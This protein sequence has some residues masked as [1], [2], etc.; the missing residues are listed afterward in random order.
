M[1]RKFNSMIA[2]ICAH[3]YFY[4]YIFFLSLVRIVYGYLIPVSI[5]PG[6]PHDDTLFYRLAYEISQFRWL[7]EYQNTTQIKGFIFPLF[8]SIPITLHIPLRV[9]ESLFICLSSY[10]F[11]ASLSLM[12]IKVVFRGLAYT[13]IIFYPFQYGAVDFRILRDMIYPQEILLIFTSLLFIFLYLKDGSMLYKRHA[14]ALGLFFFAYI[15]TREEW[16]WILPI[17]I[18]SLVLIFLNITDKKLYLKSFVLVMVSVIL[19]TALVKAVTYYKYRSTILNIFRDGNFQNGYGALHRIKGEKRILESVTFEDFE[20]IFSVSPTAAKMSN[21]IHSNAYKG[22]IGTG[23][24]AHEATGKDIINK[25]RCPNEMP[26]GFLMFAWMDGLWGIGIQKPKDVSNFMK[27]IAIEIND[28]CSKGSIICQ[29]APAFML[30]PAIYDG[31]IKFEDFKREFYRG[32]DIYFRYGNPS[33]ISFEGVGEITALM[34]ISQK[35]GGFIFKMPTPIVTPL[36][37]IPE[38]IVTEPSLRPGWV[39]RITYD[40]NKVRIDGWAFHNGDKFNSIHI[41]LDGNEVC[42]TEPRTDRVDINLKSPDK[43]GFTCQFVGIIKPESS[44]K[45]EVFAAIHYKKIQYP[46]N[47]T[48]DV[49]FRIINKFD[50]GQY[51]S[52]NP[53]VQIFVNRTKKTAINHWQQIGQFE[54]RPGAPLYREDKISDEDYEKYTYNYSSYFSYIFDLNSNIY[55]F[56]NKYGVF[57]LVGVFLCLAIARK[58]MEFYIV[59]VPVSLSILRLILLSILDVSGLAPI[60]PLYLNAGMYCYFIS[61]ILGA[62]FFISLIQENLLSKIK[63]RS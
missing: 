37:G 10:Y 7:G 13:I 60:S 34:R 48:D 43:I 41:N 63:M 46:L 22:W 8:L 17:F 16:V 5:L 39:D 20:K 15:N 44:R 33:L 35:L 38:G 56:I 30:P 36:I 51:T 4:A 29:P 55:T 2:C 45:L 47:L 23:C 24:Y 28:A 59:F 58:W 40:G 54:N 3:K 52:L 14:I 50:E 9:F 27:N 11:V 62:V 25:S 32:M 61:I 18:L 42:V 53:D 26:I 1:Y 6:A 57:I 12:H 19:C 49:K 21:Y 31:S